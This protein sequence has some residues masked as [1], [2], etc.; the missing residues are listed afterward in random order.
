MNFELLISPMAV[1]EMDDAYAFYENSSVG[2]GDRFLRSLEKT[3]K[4][5]SQTPEYYSY[6]T[7]AKDARDVKLKDFRSVVIFQR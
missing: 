4:K 2:S 7:K 6:I 5:L 1:P 3:Y